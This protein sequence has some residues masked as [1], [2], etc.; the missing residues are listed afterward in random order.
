MSEENLFAEV[1]VQESETQIEVVKDL[2]AEIQAQLQGAKTQLK[3][4]NLLSDQQWH[5]RKCEGKQVASEQYAG[6]GGI[7]GLQ[8]GSL[9]RPGLVIETTK[10]NCPEC[11][12]KTTWDRWI[13]EI[14]S[15]NSAANIPASLVQRILKV[16]SYTDVI[17]QRQRAAH[18]L[19]ID[20]RFPME[21]WGESEPPHLTSMSEDEIKKKFQL[22]KKDASGNHNLLKSRSCERCIRTGKRGTP[23]G[24]KFWYEGSEDWSSVH[25][26]SAEAEEGCIGCGWYNFEV[27]RDSLNQ[28]LSKSAQDG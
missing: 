25:Q 20:H 9:Q 13:G 23:F 12:Q 27:W 15:A 24:I 7:Q 5:C 19:V 22:L 3:V 26:R 16:Y 1:Q 21:R 28:K 17:E 11:K 6:G 2:V 10:K 4:F 8:R 18:E 14:K